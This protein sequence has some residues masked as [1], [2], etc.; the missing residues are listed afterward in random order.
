MEYLL[1]NPCKVMVDTGE[2]YLCSPFKLDFT[3][4]YTLE[5]PNN[6]TVISYGY[7]VEG[8][9]MV[10]YMVIVDYGYS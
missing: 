4:F 6:L 5:I 2:S 1:K 7:M 9:G 3:S 10:K 8:E